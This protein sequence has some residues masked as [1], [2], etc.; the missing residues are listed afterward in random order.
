MILQVEPAF[1]KF[2][3]Y[4]QQCNR[5]LY[6]VREPSG[7]NL[8]ETTM[9][10]F[11]AET[12]CF[13]KDLSSPRDKAW[14]EEN[15]GRYENSLLGP[16]R[17]AVADI[18]PSLREVIKD[19]EIRPAVNKTITRINR[20]MRFAKGQSLY[21]NNMLALFYRERRKRLDAQL[22][23]GLQPESIWRGLYVP[24]PLLAADG[25][26]ARKIENDP[27]VVVNMAKD[28]GLGADID[29]VACKKYGDVDRT[30]DPAK[31]KS[32]LEGPHL[33]ALQVC[34]PDEV[35]ADP[36][37]FIRETRDLL[38]RLVPLWNLYSVAVK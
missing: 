6:D 8:G 9:K 13:L 25:P 21:K 2:R 17:Q 29:L 16:L 26:I 1:P 3:K 28:I 35:T 7:L 12:F 24:T 31:A 18:G 4:W 34:E 37:A 14:F 11:S 10:H 38:V 27:H 32:F 20:D 15:R 5:L 36:T 22:F 33:C 23:L 30:L 19:C